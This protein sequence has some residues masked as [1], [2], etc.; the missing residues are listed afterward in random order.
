MALRTMARSRDRRTTA[1]GAFGLFY[2]GGVQY[3]I[4]V[5][6]FTRLFPNAAAFAG[7]PPPPPPPTPPSSSNPNRGHNR[8][9][10]ST[11]PYT[12]PYT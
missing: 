4:Y 12:W 11:W 8:R 5:P 1:F 3:F 2:L 7:K 9:L 10:L 6:L